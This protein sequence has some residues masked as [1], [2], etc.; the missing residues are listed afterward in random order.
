MSGR[1]EV[2][3]VSRL[4]RKEDRGFRGNTYFLAVLVCFSR[5]AGQRS[6]SR[7]LVSRV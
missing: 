2:L 3:F 7:I 1:R 4:L 6:Q 5:K